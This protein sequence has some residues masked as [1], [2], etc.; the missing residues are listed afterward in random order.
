MGTTEI[1][2]ERC[3]KAVT[4][5]DQQ[6][7]RLDVEA[8]TDRTDTKSGVIRFNGTEVHNCTSDSN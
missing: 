1:T 6:D 3:G 2:C 5:D 4:I 8:G 7:I